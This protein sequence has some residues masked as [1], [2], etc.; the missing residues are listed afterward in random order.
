MADSSLPHQTL[1]NISTTEGGQSFAGIN[2]GTIKYAHSSHNSKKDLDCIKSLRLT[3]PRHDKM[4]I[5]DI[6]GGILED[7]YQWILDSAYFRQWQDHKQSRLLWITGDPGK[8]KTM[9]LCGI[10]NELQK[11]KADTDLLAYF[12]C[13]ATDQR[14][15]NAISVLRG[16]M[17]LLVDQQPSLVSHIQ[18]YD[19]A[20]KALFEDPNAWVALSE[21][22]TSI[23]EDSGLNNTYLIIDALDECVKD[24]PKLLDFI[25]QKSS[26]SPHIKWIISSR[27]GVNI[28]R[29][30]RL[31]KSATC[32]SLE[33][34]ENAEQVSRAVNTY[35]H[36]CVSE[37]ANIQLDKDLQDS[38]AQEMQRKANGTFLWVSLVM[39][40]LKEAMAWEVLQILSEVPTELKDMYYRMLGQIKQLQRQNPELCRQVLSTVITTY[41]PL[42][43][44]ELHVLSG[45]PTLLKDVNQST[46]AI[47]QMCGSFLTIRNDIV[48][49][50]HQSARDFLAT[51]ASHDI[52]PY[53]ARDVHKSVF[54]KSLHAMS[55]TLRR[56][57]YSLREFGYPIEQVKQPDPDPLAASRYSCVYWVDHLC[58]WNNNSSMD[59]YV[60]LQD[61]G[62]IDSFLR[63][64]YLYWLEAL[65]LCNSMPRGVVS[66]AKLKALIQGRED[67]SE[68]NRL[69]QDAHRFIM[70]HKWA[71]ENNPLQAYMSALIFSPT[72]SLIRDIFKKEEPDWITIKPNIGDKWS[73]CLQTLEGHRGKVTSVAFSHG[74]TRLASA[75][76][77]Q[78]VKIWDTS[79]G[80]CLQTLEGH[81]NIVY[82]V[83]F[84]HDSSRLASASEDQTVKIWDLSN[85]N[86]L[87]TLKGNG[88]SITSVAFSHDSTWLALASTDQ[89]AKIWG[90]SGAGCLQTLK[91][92]SRLVT[93]VAFSHN[94]TRL[95]SASWDQTVKIWDLS[96]NSCLQ[97][98]K[99]H[100]D[101]ITSVT[102]SYDSTWVAS[103]SYDKTVKIWD[104]SS[105]NCLQTLKGHN[106][107]A[108]SVVFSHD[109][110]WLASSS[111]DQTVKIWDPSNGDCLQ[112]L[113]GHSDIVNS[114]VFSHDSLQLASASWDQT[115]KIW[116]PRNG[117]C[118]QMFK[119][120]SHPVNLVAFSYDATWLASASDD[121]T[122][123][124]WDPNSGDCLQTLKGHRHPITSMAFSYNSIWLASASIDRTVKIWDPSNG[125][126]LQ[127]LKGH[128]DYITSVAFSHDSTRLV[129]ASWD[130][131]VRIWDPSNG[132]CLQTFSSGQILYHISFDITDSYLLTEVDPI[133]S[134]DS[135]SSMSEPQDPEY[136][137]LSI[138][139]DG[140]WVRHNSENL[141]WLPSEYRPSCSTVLGKAIGIGLETGGV[142][143]CKV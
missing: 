70:S 115:V 24:L 71:I 143:I 37:L 140:V 51:E 97:T 121:Q 72:H 142:W 133:M 53:G 138:S 98:L 123:K 82:S 130:Q 23:L 74:S 92:H 112:T 58:N 27:N 90:L 55:G 41:R 61:G 139:S 68:L 69:V 21:I 5:E 25:V 77:D 4:R 103:G 10:I 131:T 80:D 137:K 84:S 102:F 54:L 108:T 78:T 43:L 35:I 66:M 141:L 134:S 29:R 1:H 12:F 119:G 63:K 111:E 14:I 99:G 60:N 42:H 56:D 89:T 17:Y 129:S 135:A 136:R 30:L 104:P 126:C 118:V 40:E 2:L 13:Q 16:L 81:S 107:P 20:G 101:Y 45:L 94:S 31:H 93:S 3:D 75:S 105:G 67:N 128:S 33:L 57:I 32:L 117:D 46:T 65:S 95:A 116:D 62:I 48:Y 49:I 15:N 38:V 100:G 122:V 79:S 132:D 124:I 76:Y 22:F 127:T 91:G 39:K 50:I 7:S 87:Q 8:G 36:H 18:K 110:T 73:S 120:H 11:S 114:V 47:V 19:Y 88:H 83:A 85:G 109:S 106:Y 113:K 26:I 64:Q 96:S 52:F 9:L 28:E 125:N 59:Y 34:K 44:Q 6:K 86:C